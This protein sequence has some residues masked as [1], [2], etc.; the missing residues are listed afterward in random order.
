M[1]TSRLLC[2][3]EST[4]VL[5]DFSYRK[6]VILISDR[7]GQQ[8]GNYRLVSPLGKGGFAE[9]YLAEHIHLRYLVAIKFLHADL[10]KL[11]S[12]FSD[13]ARLVAQLQ[14]PHIIRL[15][16]FGIGTSPYLIMEYAAGGTL[17][18]MYPR[19]VR[20]A[21]ALVAR[22]VEQIASALQYV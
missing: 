14:H 7:T 6:R 17:R 4:L 22:Y 21:P 1:A 12:Q 10:G 19:G 18:G 9:V 15:M 20:V 8:V 2:F 16:D 13:E 5:V 11:E 3:L